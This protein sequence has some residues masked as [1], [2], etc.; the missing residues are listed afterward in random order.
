ML[1]AAERQSA[2]VLDFYM[3]EV[4]RIGRR[5][6]L[7]E[8]LVD[9]DDELMALAEAS[10][11]RAPSRADEPYRRA[12]IGI[13]ARLAATSQGLGHVIRQRRP[14]G[15]AAPYADSMEF[16]RE[17]D[18]VIH[19]LKQHKS[20]LLARGDLRHR[21]AGG[22]GIRFSSRAARHAPAQQH[23]RASR[24]RVVR[25]RRAAA[26]VIPICPRQ[27]AYSG[28]WPKSAAHG[29]CVRLIWNIPNSSKASWP[30]FKRQR[31]FTAASARRV[32]KLYYFQNRWRFRLAGDRTV[33]ERSGAPA[34]R[35]K[36]ASASQYRS[37]IRNYC[38]LARL[39]Q[40]HGRVVFVAVLPQASGFAT[41]MFRK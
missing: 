24:G 5:L 21:P 6:S 37:A 11:D 32:A 17:L 2:L 31:I 7:T 35:G 36:T 29:P 10:P 1:H 15:S 34:R 9:V 26:R 23:S 22:R 27:N 12:L 41:A 13:Y 30:F 28:C 16:V 20:A 19:S 40:R 4:H 39:R 33:A 3:G 14:V 25:L 38:G 18:I 8:R